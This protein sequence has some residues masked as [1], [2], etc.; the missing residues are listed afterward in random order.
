[1]AFPYN[2]TIHV[3]DWQSTLVQFV[4]ASSTVES[5]YCTTSFEMFSNY[6]TFFF[7]N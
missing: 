1:M 6:Y 2:Y 3:F 7:I 5:I 4:I